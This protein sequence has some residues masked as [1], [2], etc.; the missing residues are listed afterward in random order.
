[1]IL[2]LA[3]ASIPQLAVGQVAVSD[4]PVFLP[5]VTNE[6]IPIPP[7]ESGKFNV[8]FVYVGPIGESGWTYGHNEGRIYLEEQLSATVHTAC[9]ENRPV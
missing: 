8:A 5:I 2:A 9:S 4:G 1:V 3:L 7:I 6:N